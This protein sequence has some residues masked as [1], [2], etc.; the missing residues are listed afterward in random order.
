[1]NDAK[2]TQKQEQSEVDFERLVRELEERIRTLEKLFLEMY[3]KPNNP[4]HWEDMNILL[5]RIKG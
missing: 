2:N 3:T 4:T 1:M 5:D